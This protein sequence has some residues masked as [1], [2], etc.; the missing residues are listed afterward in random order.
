M[1]PGRLRERC[2]R[3]GRVCTSALLGMADSLLVPLLV[4]KM[5]LDLLLLARQ[6]H[7]K[8]RPL[9]T[10]LQRVPVVELPD[11]V[12]ELWVDDRNAPKEQVT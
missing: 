3:L 6:I 5:A 8:G 11:T 12:T 10:L 4:A 9:V 7:K 1:N 2:R